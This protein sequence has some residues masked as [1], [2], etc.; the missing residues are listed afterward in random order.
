MLK[1]AK[2]LAHRNAETFFLKISYILERRCDPNKT[3]EKKEWASFIAFFPLRHGYST[4][5]DRQKEIQNRI[6]LAV[7]IIEKMTNRSVNIYQQ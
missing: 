1:N 4:K 3:T 7:S 6:C 2:R 5:G